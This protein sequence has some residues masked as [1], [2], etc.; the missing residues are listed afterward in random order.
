MLAGR[1]V[2]RQNK[3]IDRRDHVK[4]FRELAVVCHLFN[5]NVAYAEIAQAIGITLNAAHSLFAHGTGKRTRSVPFFARSARA[6]CR[7]RQEPGTYRQGLTEIGAREP[8]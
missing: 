4:S 1:N 3:S 8:L 6:P 5:L 2:A 7:C